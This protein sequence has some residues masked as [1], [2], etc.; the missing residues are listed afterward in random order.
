MS[1]Q[2]SA[3]VLLDKEARLK[4]ALRQC[5]Q[6]VI[7][8]S[9]GVDSSLLAYYARL[10]LGTNALIVIAVSPSLAAEELVAARAQA[11]DF[12]FDLLEICTAELDNPDYKR[13]DGRRCYFCKSELFDKLDEI[14]RERNIPFVAYGANVD[15]LQ[16]YRPGHQ[17]AREHQVISPLQQAGL[18]KQEI[19]ELARRAGLPSWDRPQAACL[20]S[21]FPTFVP[22]TV[23]RLAQVEQAEAYLHGLGFRQV[24]VRHHDLIA[25]IELDPAEMVSFS[26]NPQ[27][28]A[29]VSARLKELGY[30]YVTLDLDGYRQGSAN[31]VTESL[32][33]PVPAPATTMVL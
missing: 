8:Y 15:D 2:D 1:R 14:A 11:A 33:E 6:I 17:A 4:D 31:L 25:R 26:C 12:A 10:V 3:A 30:K 32:A 5:G 22:V 7:A 19:R 27:L 24:R 16:D 20:A 21:R 23:D 13:N 29:A 18:E 28:F 9:G